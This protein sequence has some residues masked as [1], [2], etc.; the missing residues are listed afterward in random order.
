MDNRGKGPEAVVL[1]E[2]FLE[3]VRCDLVLRD[4][5]GQLDVEGVAG[6]ETC[7]SFRGKK[8]WPLAKEVCVSAAG[9]AARKI[10]SESRHVCAQR[11]WAFYLV[12][13]GFPH[14]SHLFAITAVFP[15]CTP[16]VYEFTAISLDRLHFYFTHPTTVSQTLAFVKPCVLFPDYLFPSKLIKHKH[17]P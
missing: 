16:F 10:G 15:T 4:S 12:G 3:E 11:I 17:Q 8:T 6:G 7:G 1:R 9:S 14:L 13:Q 5:E 2:G